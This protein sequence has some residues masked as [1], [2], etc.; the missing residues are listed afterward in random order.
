MSHTGKCEDFLSQECDG[1][2]FLVP[3]CTAALELSCMMILEP[4]DE[5]I[6]PSWAFP[7]C[8]NAVIL[9]GATPVFVDVD[10]N[11]NIDPEEVI[12]AITPKTKAIMPLHYAGVK[13]QMD[14]II[15]IAEKYGLY[16]IEDAAQAIGN[17][18]IMGDF[19]CLSFHYTKNIQCGQGGAI[20]VKNERFLDRV[21]L[22]MHCGTDKYKFYNNERDRYD[23]LTVGS[24]YIMSEYAA[25][26]LY[27]ELQRIDEITDK[28]MSIWEIYS[29]CCPDHGHRAVEIGNGHIFWFDMPD[30]WAW[31][32]QMRMCG[33]K[34]SSHFEALHLTIPGRKYGR[35]VGPINTATRAMKRLV[36]LDTSVSEDSALTACEILWPGSTADTRSIL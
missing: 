25:E 31:M 13:P 1:H 36:K 35:A 18:K 34:V 11:L 9:R 21:K 4:G 14:R 20:V 32:T 5:V 12:K 29:R 22:M 17:W 15:A 23:W 16:V 8:A 7:S 19:G 28:R 26:K 3:S 33:V 10:S 2:A 27:D 24:Q 30:K 6:L